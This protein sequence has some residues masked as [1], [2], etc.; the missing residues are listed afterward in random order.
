MLM[1]RG[2]PEVGVH[3]AN[4][5]IYLGGQQFC[6]AGANPA[7]A[8]AGLA[9]GRDYTYGW[10]RLRAPEIRRA[11]ASSVPRVATLPSQTAAAVGHAPVALATVRGWNPEE[12]FSA[13]ADALERQAGRVFR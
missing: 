7:A 8:I 11:S 12:M 13:P 6:D 3:Q 4:P 2:A 9:A 1:Q 10:I 5:P